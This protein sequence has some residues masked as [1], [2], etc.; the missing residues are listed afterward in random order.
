MNNNRKTKKG[1]ATKRKKTALKKTLFERLNPYLASKNRIL[2]GLILG[3]SVLFSILL[4]DAKIN[5]MGDDAEYIMYGYNFATHFDFPSFRGPLYPVLLSPFILLFG[6][7]IVLLKILSGIMIVGS[8]FFM[9]KTLHRRIPALILFSSLFLLSSN[10]FLLFYSSAVLSEPLFLLIQSLLIFFFCTYFVDTKQEVS[11]KTRILRFFVI[12]VLVL[13]LTLTRTVGYAAIGVIAGYFL[14][15]KQW[16]NALLSILANATVFGLFGVLKKILWPTSGSAYNLSAFFTKDMYNPDKGMEDVGGIIVRLFENITNYLS[17]HIYPFFGLQTNIENS[18]IF[19]TVIIVFLF[20][21]G[22]Y[23]AYRK[24]RTLF[25]AAL[26]TLG[27]CLANFIILHATWL[28]ERF[29]IV[30]YPLILLVILAGIYYIVQLNRHTHFLYIA[31]VAVLFVGSFKQTLSK[32]EMNATALRMYLSG[33]LLYGL[34]PDWQNY[35]QVSQRAAKEIPASVNIAVRKPGTSTMYGNR[36]FHGIYAVPSVP[37]DTLN[38]WSPAAGK[39]VFIADITTKHIPAISKYLT[40]VAYG[41]MEIN[42]AVSQMAGIYEIDA[43][44]SP[45][46]KILT[47]DK[48]IV[49]TSDYE[50]YK[51]SFLKTS[52]NLLYSPDMMLDNLKKANVQYMILASLRLNPAANTGNIITTMHRYLT[53]LQLKYPDIAVEKFS[54]GEAEPASLIELRY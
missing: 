17:R 14:F 25:F 9:Y 18:S 11:I 5:M 2:L 35:I 27:F 1:G 10:S 20:L 47:G 22:G 50:Q 32:T 43:S 23:M 54:I 13:C 45:L 12:A 6:V 38:I 51:E 16:K 33:N 44:D 28:Q 49:C 40:F 39:T 7:N 31:L 21:L 29:I 30:Y 26:H 42:G 37:K 3:L 15:F 52:D 48:S 19:I 41:N 36:P 53:I 8:L 4:F 24:N 34:T 46:I